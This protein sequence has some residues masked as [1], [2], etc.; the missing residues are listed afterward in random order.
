MEKKNFTYTV[1]ESLFIKEKDFAEFAKGKK[2]KDY[3]NPYYKEVDDKSVHIIPANE[4]IV[5][6]P[7]SDDQK[8][9]YGIR[10]E[11]VV[12][13]GSVTVL[14]WFPTEIVCGVM[15]SPGYHDRYS[16]QSPLAKKTGWTDTN[17]DFGSRND[18]FK[19][20][21]VKVA[22]RLLREAGFNVEFQL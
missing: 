6:K 3:P 9:W 17:G 8:Q 4:K 18:A 19:E 14:G 13:E 15:R 7:M 1:L 20:C 16:A 11:G 2:V 10:V 21:G 5:F 12:Y 22:A